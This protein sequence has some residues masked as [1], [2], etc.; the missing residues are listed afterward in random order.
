MVPTYHYVSNE[1]RELKAVKK[2]DYIR[3]VTV[4]RGFLTLHFHEPYNHDRQFLHEHF[5]ILELI[6]K[7][8]VSIW[9]IPFSSST[10][11]EY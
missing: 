10:D 5:K 8:F 2:M 9:L 11:G 4:K 1:N 3:G 7:T 6:F